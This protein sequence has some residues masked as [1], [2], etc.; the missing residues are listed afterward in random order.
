[1]ETEEL[2]YP[3][4]PPR[5]KWGG[6]DRYRDQIRV[7]GTVWTKDTLREE[8]LIIIVEPP[9]IKVWQLH[10]EYGNY[11]WVPYG[12]FDTEQECYNVA[13]MHAW[14]GTADFTFLPEE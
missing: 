8:E 9:L 13:A 12:P 4:L 3:E 7:V 1:M 5:H 10:D 14:L 11:V 6:T 2:I